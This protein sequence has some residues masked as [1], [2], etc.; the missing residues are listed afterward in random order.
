MNAMIRCANDDVF[1]GLLSGSLVAG[2]IDSQH[3]N[4]RFDGLEFHSFF[5]KDRYPFVSVY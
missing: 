5:A 1:Y 3:K 4:E 2:V